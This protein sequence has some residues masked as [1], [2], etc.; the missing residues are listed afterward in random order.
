MPRILIP[1]LLV[2]TLAVPFS[3]AWGGLVS[4]WMENGCIA[5]PDGRC[6]TGQVLEPAPDNGCGLDPHGGCSAGS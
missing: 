3:R 1:A 5:D 2:F 4:L 6:T